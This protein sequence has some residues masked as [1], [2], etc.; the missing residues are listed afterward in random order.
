MAK[1]T[2][3][4]QLQKIKKEKEALIEKNRS[5]AEI[6]EEITKDD[7]DRSHSDGD[8]SHVVRREIESELS[9]LDEKLKGLDK[10]SELAEKVSELSEKV[11]SAPAEKPKTVK[12]QGPLGETEVPV[13]QAGA[14]PTDNP[15]AV[16][17]P[18]TQ[19]TEIAANVL[20]GQPTPP[21][22][23]GKA[24]ASFGEDVDFQTEI[25]EINNKVADVNKNLNAL[26]KKMEYRVSRLEEETKA[27][28]R[29]GELEKGFEEISEKLSPENVAKLKKLIFS[30][31]ELVDEVIPDLINKRLRTRIDPL[32]SDLGNVKN[33]MEVINNRMVSFRNDLKQLQK[34]END[35]NELGMNLKIER[36]RTDKK[37]SDYEDKAL[38]SM[39]NLREETRKKFEKVIDDLSKVQTKS[40]QLIADVVK[41]MFM[42]I[43]DPKLSDIE[44]DHVVF[45]ERLNKLFDSIEKVKRHISKLQAPENLKEWIDDKG[46]EIEKK[47]QIEVTAV[48]KD[49]LNVIESVS[50]E[51]EKNDHEIEEIKKEISIL[52]DIQRQSLKHT[53]QIADVTDKARKLEQGTKD[54]PKQ[55][56]Y[57]LKQIN[58]LSDTRDLFGRDIEKLFAETKVLNEKSL[59]SDKDVSSIFSELKATEKSVD[60][61]FGGL[62]KDILSL[63]D[64]IKTLESFSNKLA[65]DTDNTETKLREDLSDMRAGISAFLEKK[66]DDLKKDLERVRDRDLRTQIDQFKT[67]LK[68]V[69]KI[70]SDIN[71]LR[72]SHS[73]VSERMLTDIS[74]LE[75]TPNDIEFLRE[76]IDAL[77]QVNQTF[78]KRLGT[79]IPE[80]MS[81]LADEKVKEAVEDFS[82]DIAR[83]KTTLDRENAISS[84]RLNSF[85]SEMNDLNKEREVLAKHTELLESGVKDLEGELNAGKD[86]IASLEQESLNSV[87]LNESRFSDVSQNTASLQKDLL[88]Q[89]KIID[90]EMKAHAEDIKAEKENITEIE[91][92]AVSAIKLNESRFSD[93]SQ[94]T[95]SLQK[96]LSA[97]SGNMGVRLDQLQADIA[98]DRDRISAVEKIAENVHETRLDKISQDIASIEQEVSNVQAFS[99]NIAKDFTSSAGT[100]RDDLSGAEAKMAAKFDTTITNLRSELAV[101]RDK[102]FRNQ[103]EKFEQEMARLSGIEKNVSNLR[104][105]QQ[106]TSKGHAGKISMLEKA[107]GEIKYLRDKV[108]SL[109]EENKQ[110]AQIVSVNQVQIAK[111]LQEKSIE[112]AKL[113][114]DLSKQKTKIGKLLN[115]LR[116]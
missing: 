85:Q 46:K 18:P 116:T 29:I 100:L 84:A 45:D 96:D 102:E 54:M 24:L 26:Q 101:A 57:Q 36:E 56:D 25:I 72:K 50:N 78:D 41:E 74:R 109:E 73:D 4:K 2:G 40:S 3:D 77:E 99:N 83:M 33:A 47:L 95:A 107:L 80:A 90:S 49:R 65:S 76:K 110:L 91:K 105:V 16:G 66:T 114:K 42:G 92:E 79:D 89:R 93:V 32:L 53:E 64:N 21:G 115:E 51:V 69:S 75:G 22:P 30:T 59:K 8:V 19:G 44:K 1:K 39:E 58:R 31:D 81:S 94:N 28:D 38:E 43:V 23:V 10:I 55:L 61:R 67:E 104:S 12:V 112:R 27:L 9:G 108:E 113:E 60:A 111:A 70:E 106:E 17:L 71:F 15:N 97:Q 35:V 63:N 68:K 37:V 14:A 82:E 88:T 5:L 20:A 87:K 98:S 6:I 86:R 13:D 62:S 48:L 52:S 11:K 103:A 34:F 7:D